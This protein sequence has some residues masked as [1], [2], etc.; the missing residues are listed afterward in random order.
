MGDYDK[1]VDFWD[2]STGYK[3]KARIMCSDPVYLSLFDAE[4]EVEFAGW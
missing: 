4:A 1:R 2:F 3:V